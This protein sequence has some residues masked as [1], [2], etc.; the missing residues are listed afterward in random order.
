MAE[1]PVDGSRLSRRRSRLLPPF[2][3]EGARRPSRTYVRAR[4]R[5]TATDAASRTEAASR[6]PCRGVRH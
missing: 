6:R 4:V 1:A 5:G 3:G 2:T